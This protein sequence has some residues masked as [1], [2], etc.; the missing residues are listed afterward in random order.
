MLVRENDS[1]SRHHRQDS[2]DPHIA[3]S[4]SRHR[5]LVQSFALGVVGAPP[6]SRRRRR[7]HLSNIHVVTFAQC[8]YG[9]RRWLRILEG[10]PCIGCFYPRTRT[11]DARSLDPGRRRADSGPGFCNSAGLVSFPHRRTAAVRRPWVFR[12][13]RRSSARHRC[14]YRPRRLSRTRSTITPACPR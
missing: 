7:W 1:G 14:T 5:I 4:S 13:M 11:L 12:G 2:V 9:G 3:T 8:A 6:R 10:S